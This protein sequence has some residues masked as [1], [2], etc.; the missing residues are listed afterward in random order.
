[1]S[2]GSKGLFKV[3]PVSFT[4]TNHDVTDLLNHWLEYLE[5]GTYFFFEIKK[6]FTCAS[7][8]TS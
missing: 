3:D 6:S 5:Y 8:D 2:C 7:D 4:N 1:M